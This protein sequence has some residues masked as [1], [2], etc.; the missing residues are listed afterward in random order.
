MTQPLILAFDTS[1]PHCAIALLQGETVLA[2][3]FEEMAKGQAERLMPLIEATLAEDGLPL[4]VLD[5][6]AVGIGPGNFT[7]IRIA[8]SAARG[9][10]LAL[11]TP[12][13]GV[14]NFEV[15]RGPNSRRDHEPQLVSLPAPRGTV[16]LQA[17]KDGREDGQAHMLRTLQDPFWELF[18]ASASRPILGQWAEDLALY[19]PP[20]YDPSGPPAQD[21]ELPARLSA[22]II[23]AIAADKLADGHDHPR[24]APLYIKP[25]DAAPSREAGPTI[26]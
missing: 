10:A 7:G 21:R 11:G 4:D 15:M 13:I 20:S 12:A 26:L 8:V 18:D 5:A 9:L 25:A 6:I 22:Q 14:S 3:R 17:F 1:G 16:F 19:H 2:S 24:P 23:G